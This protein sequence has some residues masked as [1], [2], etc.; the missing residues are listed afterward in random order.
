MKK[1]LIISLT[2]FAGL[3]LILGLN[4]TEISRFGYGIELPFGWQEPIPQEDVFCTLQARFEDGVP[5][6]YERPTHT[7]QTATNTLAQ[8]LNIFIG[9]GVGV[10][11]GLF[12][13]GSGRKY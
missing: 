7:C 1:I 5:F 11:I 6:S 3:V 12:A 9:I 8:L 10:A 4:S 13:K 2:A